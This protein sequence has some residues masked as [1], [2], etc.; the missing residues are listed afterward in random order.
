MAKA[1]NPYLVFNGTCGAAF[2][3]YHSVFGGEFVTRMTF[4]DSGGMSD[5]PEMPAEEKDKIMHVSLPIGSSV[6]M[7]SDCPASRGPVI[8]GDN[9]AVSVGVVSEAEGDQVLAGLAEGGQT[10]MPMGK[11]FWGAYFGMCKDRFGITWQVSYD[12]DRLSVE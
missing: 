5:G 12:Y 10:L 8:V 11:T 9:I 2:D 3:L 4:G 1:A 7:G 6:L